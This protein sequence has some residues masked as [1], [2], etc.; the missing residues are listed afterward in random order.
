[1][2]KAGSVPELAGL[3]ETTPASVLL[4]VIERLVTELQAVREELGQARDEINRLK[5]EQGRPTGLKKK[6]KRVDQSSE[7]ERRAPPKTWHKKAK[8]PEIVVDRV[9][10]CTLDPAALPADAKLKDHV[11]V[12]VQDL[13]LRTDN[14]RLHCE[15]WDAASTGKTYHA[16]VPPGYEG[17]FGPGLKA[18]T[19]TLSYDGNMGQ[20]AI[21]KLFTSVGVVVS[22]GYIGSLLTNTDGF[23]AEAQAVGKAGLACDGY[24]HLDVTPTKVAGVEHECHVLGNTAF[25]FYHTD[26]Y[27][28]RQAA[29]RT[30]Q[31][32]A[33]NTFQ[34][35][36]AAWT[37]LSLG[38]PLAERTRRMLETVPAQRLFTKAAWHTWLDTH[39]RGLGPQQRQRL[40][41]AAGVGAYHGQSAVPIVDTLVCDDAP[42]FKGL[43]D[44]LQLC[45]VHE[46]RH[47]KKLTPAITAHQVLLDGYLTD[48][49]AYYRRLRAYQAAPTP[50]DAAALAADFDTLFSRQTG[51]A[52][53]DDRI[54]LT[55]AKRQ[56]L[57][58]VL[59]KPYLP[60]TNNPAELAARRRVRK[61]DVS[62]GAR[63]LAGLHAWDV[64]H[65]LIGTASLL[66]VNVLHYFYDRFS[67]A[68]RIPVLADLIQQR[69]DQLAAALPTAA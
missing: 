13:V 40:T 36:A 7:R 60:L 58:R 63:S 34:V 30:L 45:W 69:A 17:E 32:G 35:N 67:R 14:V 66:G 31:L 26:L 43:T 44:D 53:L 28:D 6:Q 16:P 54:A 22:K 20:A 42:T 29:L 39:L 12:I 68:G 25:V 38:A 37:F 64:F 52:D 19:L 50:A 8:L 1:M 59:D 41:D 48:F 55:K 9:V 46:G 57:L 10:E 62:F 49:W 15:R 4:N 33:E 24:A 27:R 2:V 61:R 56:P 11:D 3:D 47:Y 51:Y 18:L 65:T 23:A 5:G 21:R